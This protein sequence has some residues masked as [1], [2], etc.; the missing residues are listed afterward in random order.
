MSA[1]RRW[2]GPAIGLVSIGLIA[3]AGTTAV[4]ATA[5]PATAI[6]HP[7]VAA[8][9]MRTP[10][11]GSCNQLAGVSALSRSNVWAVGSYCTSNQIERSLVL[12]YNGTSWKVV[13]SPNI[14]AEGTT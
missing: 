9:P 8:H 7:V 6:A 5:G 10:N 11:P 12:H 14:G 4:P 13:N 1:L 3:G 2:S